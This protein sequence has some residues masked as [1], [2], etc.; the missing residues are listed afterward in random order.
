MLQDVM[1]L[2]QVSMGGLGNGVPRRY[3]QGPK[4]ISQVHEEAGLEIWVG[5]M[6]PLSKMDQSISTELTQAKQDQ[7][8]EL[9]QAEQDQSP[10]STELTQAEQ[11]QSSKLAQA[12][13]AQSTI[14]TELAQ[15]E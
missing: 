13:Q 2:R 3:E 9:A 12:E 10:I 14:S 5:N 8:S 11:A 1:D 7:S 15:A 6:Q 4:I